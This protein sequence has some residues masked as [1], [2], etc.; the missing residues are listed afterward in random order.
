M[1]RYCSLLRAGF[2]VLVLALLSSCTSLSPSKPM[3]PD[4]PLYQKWKQPGDE[5]GS[6]KIAGGLGDTS[7]ALNGASVYAPAEGDAYLDKRGCVYFARADT[8]AYL[9]RFCSLQSPKLG[10][11]QAGQPLG[12]AEIL[13]FATLLKQPDDKWALVEPDKSLLEQILKPR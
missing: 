4:L 7:I 5:I 1:R 10:H 2:V 6:Y 12:R 13:Q 9:L 3:I 8:P 11:L